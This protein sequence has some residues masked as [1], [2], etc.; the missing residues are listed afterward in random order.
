MCSSGGLAVK[1]ITSND[2][3]PGSSPGR[4][5][6]TYPQGFIF[7]SFLDLDQT[8]REHSLIPSHDV[9]PGIDCARDPSA[10]LVETDHPA[11]F[12]GRPKQRKLTLLGSGIMRKCLACHPSNVI[13]ASP[14]SRI[15]VPQVLSAPM[16]A[17]IAQLGER[18]TE[19]IRSYP[20]SGVI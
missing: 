10:R 16:N 18:Q 15:H 19:A 20:Q 8:D 12:L 5:F 4:S 13:L 2:E 9:V 3:I 7:A 6:L 11:S 1:R 14:P 17:L